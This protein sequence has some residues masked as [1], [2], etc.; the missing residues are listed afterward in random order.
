MKRI[1]YEEFLNG[2]NFR[3]NMSYES[4][5]KLMNANAQTIIEISVHL[6]TSAQKLI[7]DNS[8]RNSPYTLLLLSKVIFE[9]RSGG[10]LRSNTVPVLWFWL[11][12]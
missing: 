4:I 6:R 3:Q 12:N 5:R 10:E 2:V 9:L 8:D 7:Y 1:T 11:V